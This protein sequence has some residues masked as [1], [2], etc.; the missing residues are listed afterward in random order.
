MN[1]QIQKS[2]FEN[3]YLKSYD[4]ITKY[5][6]N[7][8]KT[9]LLN[10]MQNYWYGPIKCLFIFCVAALFKHFSELHD[11]TTKRKKWSCTHSSMPTF[12]Q[13]PIESLKGSYNYISLNVSTTLHVPGPDYSKDPESYWELYLNWCEYKDSFSLYLLSESKWPVMWTLLFSPH[14][15]HLPF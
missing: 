11:I 7:I 13:L 10:K 4:I 3:F 6:A 9:E 14:I 2:A 8:N 5:N 12:L 15:K 1:T